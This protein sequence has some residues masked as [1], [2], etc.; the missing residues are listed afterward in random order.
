VERVLPDALDLSWQLQRL[1]WQ[2]GCDG[3]CGRKR[4]TDCPARTLKGPADWE[5]RHVTG[6]LWLARP[7]SDAGRRLLPLVEPLKSILMQR[8]EVAATEPNP[9]GFVWTSDPKKD[10]HG[11]VLPLDGS[12]LDPSPDSKAW[13]A[14]LKRAGVTDVRLHDARHVTASLLNKAG[15]DQ[16]TRMAILGHSS[17]AMTQHYTDVDLGQ[18]GSALTSMSA[19]LALDSAI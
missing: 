17:P 13:D 1:S 11:R 4:G 19:F 14:L 9:H 6:G 2:H 7:K 16:A 10:R 12:P 5:H 3:D 18:L 8:I 15:V